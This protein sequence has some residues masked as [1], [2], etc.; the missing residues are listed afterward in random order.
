MNSNHLIIFPN[1]W[2]TGGMDET[3]ITYHTY[4]RIQDD[5]GDWYLTYCIK[6]S[7]SASDKQKFQLMHQFVY[8]ATKCQFMIKVD[9][10]VEDSRGVKL[11]KRDE[12][13]QDEKERRIKYY[14]R[15]N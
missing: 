5:K 11:F 12:C 14:K 6:N 2:V 9:T 3:S 13:Q 1:F 4:I 10:E 7:S 15:Q 8:E